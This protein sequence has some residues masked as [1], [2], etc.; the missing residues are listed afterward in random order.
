MKSSAALFLLLSMA[1]PCLGVINPAVASAAQSVLILTDNSGS[2]VNGASHVGDLIAAFTNAG[3]AVTTNSTELTNGLTMPA[4]LV[5]GWDVVI[6]VTVSG[7]QI[8]AGD[9]PVLQNAVTTHASGAFMFFTDACGGC[10]RG[11]VSAV[12]PIVNVAGGWSATLGSPDNSGYVGNLT[13]LYSAPFTGLPAI[14]STA[15]SPLLGV[16]WANVLYSTNAPNSPGPC[17]VVAPGTA[18]SACVFMAT[19]VTEFWVTGGISST[20]ANG[21][22]TAYLNAARGCPLQAAPTYT[23]KV[24]TTGAGSVTKTPDVPLYM[25]GSV[26]QLTASPASG[27][28]GWAGNASGSANPLSVTMN[29]DKNI[30]ATFASSDVIFASSYMS[31]NTHGTYT[32]AVA[33]GDVNA[34]GKPDLVAATTSGPSIMLGIGDGTFGAATLLP[35]SYYS[36]GLALADL[37]G[38]GVLDIATTD[39]NSN[40]AAVLLGVGDGTFRTAVTYPVGQTPRAIAIADLNGDARPDLVVANSDANTVSVL[41]GNGDGT[42]GAEVEFPAGAMP[43]GVAI[44]DLNGDGKPDLAVTDKGADAV[45]VLLGNGDGSFGA[46]TH[47]HTGSQ[48]VGIALGDLNGDGK[49]DVAVTNYASNSVSIL[50]GV[51]DGSLG[52]MSAHGV[53]LNPQ[54]VA[55]GDLNGDGKPDLAV[56]NYSPSTITLFAGDGLGGFGPRIDVDSGSFPFGVAI[57]DLNGDHVPDLA[58]AN[59]NVGAVSVSLGN[60]DGSFGVRTETSSGSGGTDIAL[61]DLNG[62]HQLDCII[63]NG[64]S[65]FSISTAIGNGDG[66]FQGSTPFQTGA[67]PV[68]M[69]VGDLNGDGKVDVV[70]ANASGSISV[71]LG[72][73]D[74]TFGPHSDYP[75]AGSPIAA[76]IGDVNGDG[77]PDVVFADNGTSVITVMLGNGDGTLGSGTNFPAGTYPQF[78]TAGDFNGDGKLDVAVS[79]F[80][81]ISVL[82]GKGDGTFQPRVGYPAPALLGIRAGDLNG[83]GKLD[84]VASTTA[85][86]IDV[87]LG[88][89]DGTFAAYKPY[90]VGN[91]S[92]YVAI[93]DL[94]GDGR[95]DVATANYS[96]T[97]SVLPGNGDGTLGPAIHYGPGPF[98]GAVAIADVTGDGRPDL[99][100]ALDGSTGGSV[101]VL[102]N[103]G[104]HPAIVAGPANQTLC[105]TQDLSLSVQANGP[106]LSYQ[107]RKNGAALTD[108]GTISGATTAALTVGSVFPS[109]AGS[110]DV[111]V[112]NT[113]GSATS[114]AAVVAICE[115]PMFAT[116]PT[117]V[118][119]VV[120][121]AAAFSVALAPACTAPIYE[122][123]KNGVALADDGRITGAATASL[124]INPVQAGDAAYYG[125]VAQNACGPQTSTQAA[126]VVN[127]CPSPPMISQQPSDVFVAIGQPASFGVIASGCIGPTYQ[128]LKDR[129]PIAGATGSNLSIPSVTDAD[130]GYYQAVVTAGG[131][132][133]I[134]NA[135]VLN[136]PAPVF[137]TATHRYLTSG[138]C[139]ITVEVYWQVNTPC[140]FRVDYEPTNSSTYTGPLTHSA[141]VTGPALTGSVDIVPPPGTLFIVYRVTATDAAN[142]TA[143]TTRRTATIP[144]ASFTVANVLPSIVTYPYA[145]ALSAPYDAVAIG[146]RVTN[147]NCSALGP[148]VDLDQARLKLAYPRDASGAITLPMPV[149]GGIAAGG[150]V[151]MPTD[152]RFLRAQ[153]GAP[154]GSK[155]TFLGRVVIRTTPPQYK[156]FSSV[157]RLP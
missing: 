35:G 5:S 125:V 49:P 82:I 128:W 147:N 66:T 2:G 58:V 103:L 42:F 108:G 79:D 72:H 16:P 141:N 105:S 131:I 126:L 36:P 9:V 30:T 133:T 62:D 37:N 98:P 96:G 104:N 118:A 119:A 17:A 156:S 55:I 51:G 135:A 52:A 8:D 101:G 116:N 48:P 65:S 32:T 144:G 53:G 132:S 26:V 7:N 91:Y 137:L 11:S 15:Y 112:S 44:G 13:G 27:F 84:L 115:K 64:G 87:L 29:S 150:T 22:A 157:V 127:V 45:A 148:R 130:A 33:I 46:Y 21:L 23:L 39:G 20:Q 38:D 41:L 106:S 155:V 145:V 123:Q 47:Y 40:V 3:A 154:P 50:L 121:A 92:Q 113:H 124:S 136:V 18:T 153:I 100:V 14:S 90:E 34:D 25:P 80:N 151:R 95:A 143:T 76:V 109:A 61:V 56:T 134:S 31:Y 1:T 59:D 89:G 83:D 93:G 99:V 107:W 102:R 57:G 138:P 149:A 70:T 142:R 19:D 97:V 28:L 69:A 4:S 24:A 75:Q 110:Y 85:Y 146:V 139:A 94:D 152:L 117:S 86:Q 122:W 12:L 63:D 88:H 81:A 71:L 77:K 54:A 140:A 6:V 74:G 67:F 10:T 129:R 120:G 68:S 73:G 114:V 78:M 43:F 60:G 111:V